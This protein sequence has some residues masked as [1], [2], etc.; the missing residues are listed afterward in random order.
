MMTPEQKRKYSQRN[1]EWRL[2]RKNYRTG[3]YRK[4]GQRQIRMAL[5]KDMDSIL[6]P[7]A[8][9]KIYDLWWTIF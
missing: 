8:Y 3:R 4:K 6:P 7:S 5:K 1:K 9:R 2:R